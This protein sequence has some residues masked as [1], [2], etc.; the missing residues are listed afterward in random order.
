M[1][2]DTK[3]KILEVGARIIHQKGYS[4]T[5]IQ[6]VLNEAGVPKGSFY[7]YFKNK[8]DFGLQ[9]LDCFFNFFKSN[10]LQFVLDESKPHIKRIELFLTEFL[11]FFTNGDFKGGC[12]IGNLS[13][14]LADINEN[15]RTHLKHIMDESSLLLAQQ[16]KLAQEKNEINNLSD[17]KDL[18]DFIF[19]SWEGMIM[20]MKVTQDTTPLERFNKY[21]FHQLLQQ[22]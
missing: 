13:L 18:A 14:E 9:V 21:I 12:P 8:E 4:A 16:I 20:Q 22:K 15:F 2:T 7:F 10:L 5:G 1:K 17:A 6:E 11:H 3:Q 19:F